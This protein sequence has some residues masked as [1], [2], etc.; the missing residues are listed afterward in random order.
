MNKKLLASINNPLLFTW[1][2]LIKL[3][4][5]LLA[6]LRLVEAT[7]R[8]AIVRVKYQYL[9]KNPFHSIYFGCLAMAAELSSGV[10]GMVY[11]MGLK[12]DV[13]M[14]IVNLEGEF[15]KKGRGRIHFVC[16]DGELM[17]KA[18][19]ETRETGEPRTV[20]ATSI[21]R[22][23]QGR[24]VARFLITWSFKAKLTKQPVPTG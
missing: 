5:G 13:S 17:G 16:E 10:L 9:T 4:M 12:P 21:G 3:P 8:H 22:D 7:E 24:E 20:T 11:T 1:F 2:L 18:A 6:G 19:Q 23:A 15:K 14:L